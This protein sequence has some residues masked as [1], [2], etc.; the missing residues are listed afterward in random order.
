MA[1]KTYAICTELAQLRLISKREVVALAWHL[2]S[3]VQNPY[4]WH[5]DFCGGVATR[6]KTVVIIR[7][8]YSCSCYM[9]SGTTIPVIICHHQVD[10]FCS[11]LWETYQP[12]GEH[13]NQSKYDL[14][15][16]YDDDECSAISNLIS[17]PDGSQLRFSH[18]LKHHG[19]RQSND[20]QCPSSK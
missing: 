6:Y 17:L 16:T 7:F 8:A 1:R 2:V 11:Y 14:G 9:P 18:R 4:L 20:H 5:Y 13:A 19:K 12:A 3:E 15:L 10:N